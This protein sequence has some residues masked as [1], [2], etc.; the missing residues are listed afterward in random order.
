[1][2]ALLPP[3]QYDVGVPDINRLLGPLQEGVDQRRKNVLSSTIGQKIGAGDYRGAA[4]A[5]FNAGEMD[6][7]ISLTKMA[8]EDKAQAVE[9][10]GRYA[11][12]SDTPEKWAKT[13]LVLS[14]KFG[15]QQ[16]LDEYGGPTGRDK[17]LAE[18]LDLKDQLSLQES[19]AKQTE[20]VGKAPD[21]V[22][23]YDKNGLAQ[24][25]V[26]NSETRKFEPVGGS[27]APAK[28]MRVITH[29]DGTVETIIGGQGGGGALD[30]TA[31]N[32]VQGKQIDTAELGSRISSIMGQ[33][34][35]EYQTLGTKFGNSMRSW[36]AFV[37]PASLSPQDKKSLGDYAAYRSNAFGNLSRYLN[38]ISGAAITPQEYERLTKVM[39][40]PGTS[41]FN[42]DDPVT[43]KSKMD[44]IATETQK[45]LARYQFYLSSP[46]GIPANLDQIPLTNVKQVSGK[47]YVKDQDGKWYESGDAA[48][49]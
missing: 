18:T 37:S 10:M 48:S 34:K 30:K 2:A 25:A 22:T 3:V 23:L 8:K 5:A 11:A 7:G 44:I 20:K 47:W 46:E 1:M 4:G 31:R 9:V 33:F 40:D 43:F 15:G 26:W 49:P 41:M 21:T 29:P 42:G 35:P 12:M 24:T 17:F 13:A 14:Q 27:K 39:P 6:T 19:R 32:T 38:E 16:F 28:G 45:A 36:K